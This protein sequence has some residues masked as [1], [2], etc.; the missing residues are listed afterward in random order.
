MRS[1]AI[2]QGATLNG[3]FY[4]PEQISGLSRFIKAAKYRGYS[5]DEVLEAWD[6]SYGLK[7]ERKRTH[8]KV[9]KAVF[10]TSG[11]SRYACVEGNMTLAQRLKLATS[12]M[13]PHDIKLCYL[14]FIET[15][16]EV[17]GLTMD[18]FGKEVA[19]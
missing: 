11:K 2:K 1:I 5:Y 9:R 15:A 19:Q 13:S 12:S 7:C 16:M 10:S 8:L 3:N 18:S 6:E 4:R 14:A 17:Y